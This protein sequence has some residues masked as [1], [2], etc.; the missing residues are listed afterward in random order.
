MR[1]SPS[2]LIKEQGPYGQLLMNLWITPIPEKVTGQVTSWIVITCSV[3][4]KSNSWVRAKIIFGHWRAHYTSNWTGYPVS[5]WGPWL[6]LMKWKSIG[7]AVP[8]ATLK[9]LMTC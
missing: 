7:P 2:T 5:F 4:S 9:E 1:L 6:F 8:Y 3:A